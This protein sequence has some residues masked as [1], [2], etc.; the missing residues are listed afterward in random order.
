MSGMAVRIFV[1]RACRTLFLPRTIYC[2]FM[3]KEELPC[4]P[5]KNLGDIHHYFQEA[6]DLMAERWPMK[7]LCDRT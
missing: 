3:T 5:Y 4:I 6:I 1:R 2:V 7:R